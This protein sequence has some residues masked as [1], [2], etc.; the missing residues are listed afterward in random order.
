MLVLQGRSV[1]IMYELSAS[2]V[3][4]R[5]SSKVSWEQFNSIFRYIK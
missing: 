4:L 2:Q 1:E 3:M 5:V